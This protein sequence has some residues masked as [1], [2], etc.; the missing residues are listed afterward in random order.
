[1]PPW[2]NR[3]LALMLLGRAGRLCRW[4]WRKPRIIGRHDWQVALPGGPLT[5]V[6]IGIGIIDLACCAAA[7]YMLMPERAQYRVRHAWR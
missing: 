1:M 4:V 7:M 5:L 2:L 6:Q 3:V